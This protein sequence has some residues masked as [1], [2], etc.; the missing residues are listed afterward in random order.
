[1]GFCGGPLLDEAARAGGWRPVAALDAAI[2]M[3]QTL[4]RPARSR[5][6]TK[7][8]GWLRLSGNP[9]Q[10]PGIYWSVREDPGCPENVM[11]RAAVSIHAGTPGAAGS[12][13]AGG[14]ARRYGREEA[15]A[16]ARSGREIASP[17]PG[18]I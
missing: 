14:I 1:L 8:G 9:T 7:R 12:I 6:E 13:A 16:R 11:F 17:T 4:Y 18:A 2:R 15:A 5:A 3:A 10:V